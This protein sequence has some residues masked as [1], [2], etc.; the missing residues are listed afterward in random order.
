MVD[1]RSLVVG[2]AAGTVAEV[3]NLLN[4]RPELVNQSPFDEGWFF[5]LKDVK[6]GALAGLMDADAYESYLKDL[7]H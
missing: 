4:D 3:N 7:D 6:P 5:K 1:R 2:A